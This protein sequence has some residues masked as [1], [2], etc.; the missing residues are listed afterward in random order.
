MLILS[1]NQLYTYVGSDCTGVFWTSGIRPP[2]Y[3]IA[4]SLEI[5]VLYWKFTTIVNLHF[6]A[7]IQH[8]PGDSNRKQSIQHLFILFSTS[9]VRN[10]ILVTCMRDAILVKVLSYDIFVIFRN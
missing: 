2:T 9:E 3:T 4:N 7:G 1:L 5:K 8:I 6:V 10:Y